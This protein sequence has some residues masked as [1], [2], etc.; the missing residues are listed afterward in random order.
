MALLTSSQNISHQRIQL[1]IQSSHSLQQLLVPIQTRNQAT[2]KRINHHRATV[3]L[4]FHHQ[5]LDWD[6]ETSSHISLQHRDCN[7]RIAQDDS[8]R[9]EAASD[10]EKRNPD[11]VI[12]LLNS[13]S[14]MFCLMT[15]GIY[16]EEHEVMRTNYFVDG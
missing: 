6:K 3:L 5:N 15:G 4:L 8:L 7:E 2:R 14:E 12:E 10:T 13:L 9:F 1:S 16:L 11:A